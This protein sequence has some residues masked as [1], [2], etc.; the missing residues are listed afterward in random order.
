MKTFKLLLGRTAV[1][2]NISATESET[3]TLDYKEERYG[4]IAFAKIDTDG[5][6]MEIGLEPCWAKFL[7]ETLQDD[8]LFELEA[9]I[10]VWKYDKEKL[11]EFDGT[12]FD[13][14]LV[15]ANEGAQYDI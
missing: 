10:E 4:H 11:Y 13:A 1:L 6:M 8:P 12:L 3:Q 14:L 9:H 7:V 2:V 5:D 15:I